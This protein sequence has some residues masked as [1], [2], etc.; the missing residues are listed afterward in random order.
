MRKDPE[1]FRLYFWYC[2]HEPEQW[3][4]TKVLPRK[5]KKRYRQIIIRNMRN[6]N[7]SEQ[8][9]KKITK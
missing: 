5:T 9:I 8:R 3:K 6:N 1:D 4:I 2:D 7:Y